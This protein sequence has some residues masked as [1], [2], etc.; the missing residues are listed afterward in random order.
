MGAEFRVKYKGL[1]GMMVQ[2]ENPGDEQMRRE[3]VTN[4]PASARERRSERGEGS[5]P[6]RS[7]E[8]KRQRTQG[9]ITSFLT[10]PTG[11]EPESSES[12]M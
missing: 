3:G 12:S 8:N 10:P 2:E 1:G 9:S 11:R 5:N 6:T 4:T 7:S